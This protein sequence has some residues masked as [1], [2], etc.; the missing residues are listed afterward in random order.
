MITLSIIL[1]IW[2]II[3]IYRLNRIAKKNDSFFNPYEGT[4]MDTFGFYVGVAIMVVWI[5]ALCIKYLP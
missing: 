4:L 1:S 5:F 3:S 2:G